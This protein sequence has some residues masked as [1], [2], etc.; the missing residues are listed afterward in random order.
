MTTL[1]KFALGNAKLT[2]T[3]GREILTLFTFKTPIFEYPKA[4][5]Y[6]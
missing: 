2:Q 6:E 5:I 4:E 1:K 3:F